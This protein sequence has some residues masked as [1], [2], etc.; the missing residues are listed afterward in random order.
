MPSEYPF[1]YIMV[2]TDYGMFIANH[3]SLLECMTYSREVFRE[4]R[5]FSPMHWNVVVLDEETYEYLRE[6]LPEGLHV[7]E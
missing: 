7:L 4:G 2:T 5:K 6:Q 3:M 1:H